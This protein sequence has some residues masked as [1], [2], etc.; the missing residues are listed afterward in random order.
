MPCGS[1][2]S[3]RPPKDEREKARQV[4][5]LMARGYGLSVALK[6]LRGAGLREPEESA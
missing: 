6:V 2:A 3:V 1:N 5:F 4:R